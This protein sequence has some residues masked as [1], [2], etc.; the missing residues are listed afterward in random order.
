[1]FFSAVQSAWCSSSEEVMR[2]I[3]GHMLESYIQRQA[4]LDK[5]ESI[6]PEY[7][8]EFD[9]RDEF[10]AYNIYSNNTLIR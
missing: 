6:C 10:Y 1:M 9:V 2:T 3:R 7:R 4:I 5:A 8:A